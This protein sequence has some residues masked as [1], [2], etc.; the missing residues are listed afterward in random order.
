M[1]AHIGHNPP[2]RPQRRLRAHQGVFN[3]GGF[4]HVPGLRP[5]TVVAEPGGQVRACRL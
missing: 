3:G 2:D 1:K 5:D 4:T